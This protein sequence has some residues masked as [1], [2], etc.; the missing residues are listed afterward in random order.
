MACLYSLVVRV[1]FVYFLTLFLEDKVCE[2]EVLIARI[3]CCV[4]IH[5]RI[6]GYFVEFGRTT[7][8]YTHKIIVDYVSTSGGSRGASE[9]PF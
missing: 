5:W 4:Q 6:Q 9:P 2:M 1:F 3:S 8:N 7:Q